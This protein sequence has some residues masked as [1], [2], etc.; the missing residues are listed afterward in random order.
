MVSS[1]LDSAEGFEVVQRK[2]SWY[3]YNGANLA[4]GRLNA[5]QYLKQNPELCAEIETQV[6]AAMK[7]SSPGNIAVD[8]ELA[9]EDSE[10]GLDEEGLDVNEALLAR[11]EA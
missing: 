1:L 6:R 11:V 4:Q 5:V 10:T 9:E 7:S 8:E 3:R 2:G